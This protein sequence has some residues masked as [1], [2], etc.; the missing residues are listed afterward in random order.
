MIVWE[1]IVDALR[2]AIFAYAQ[3]F[4]GKLRI[5]HRGRDRARAA[6]HVAADHSHGASHRG[7]SAGDGKSETRVGPAAAGDST[8]VL[9]NWR[10]KH[11]SYLPGRGSRRF[12]GPD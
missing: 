8:N 3:A 11:E 1:Q 10:R 7:A 4:G 9:N 12:R 6:G 5:R 2:I